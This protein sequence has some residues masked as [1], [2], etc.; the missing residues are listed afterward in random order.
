MQA[1]ADASALGKVEKILRE[2]IQRE[3]GVSSAAVMTAEGMPLVVLMGK[4][5]EEKLELAAAIA[6]L[7]SLSEQTA[8]RLRIGSYKDFMLRC[9]KGHL[10]VRR[11]GSSAVLALLTDRKAQLGACYVVMDS[12]SK[13]LR[14]LLK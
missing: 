8:S 12:M 6:S 7:G 3:P 14:A 11:V 1:V 10:L 2:A 4:G 5:E 9:R 13:R